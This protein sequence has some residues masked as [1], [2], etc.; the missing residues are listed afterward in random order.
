MNTRIGISLLASTA[1]LSLA[2]ACNPSGLEPITSGSTSTTSTTTSGSSGTGGT[3]GEAGSTTSSS[4]GGAPQIGC[5]PACGSAEICLEGACHGLLQLDTATAMNGGVCTIALDADNVYW[6]TSDVRRVP[7]AGGPSTLLDF[8]A[9]SPGAWWSMTPTFT[10]PTSV[11]SARRRPPPRSRE[12]ALESST[13]TRAGAP[14][15]WWGTAPTCTTS[16][17]TRSTKLP[18]PVPGPQAPPTAFTDTWS[19]VEGTP[20][21]VDA[22]SVYLWTEAASILTRVDKDDQRSAN[23]ANRGNGTIDA[24]CGIVVDATGVYF[25]T[26]PTPGRAASWPRWAAQARG[27][28]SSSAPRTAPTASSLSTTAPSIS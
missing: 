12:P 9:S 25:S 18:S 24:T 3:G 15:A 21:A 1:L 6:K 17:G 22:K 23:I 28:P 2:P 13:P 10:G 19:S 4:T 16:K 26:A 20:I 11:S 14:R 7:K 27:P 8:Q 5:S